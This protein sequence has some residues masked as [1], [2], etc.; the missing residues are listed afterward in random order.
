[1]KSVSAFKMGLVLLGAML[2]FV[3]GS[4]GRADTPYWDANWNYRKQVAITNN[5]QTTLYDYSMNISLNTAELISQGKMQSDC[6]DI[7]II[8]NGQE[9]YYG[10]TNPNSVSTEIYFIANDLVDGNNSD[11]YIYYGSPDA[12]DGF[13]QNWKDAFYIWWDD[14]DT[15]RGWYD[16]WGRGGYYTVSDGYMTVYFSPYTDVAYCPGDGSS[17]PMDKMPGLKAETK[18]M[19][20]NS[21]SCQGQ[22]VLGGWDFGSG[23]FPIP[24]ISAGH[25]RYAIGYSGLISKTINPNQWYTAEFVYNRLTGDWYGTLNGELVSGNRPALGSDDFSTIIVSGCNGNDPRVD[26]IYLRYFIEPEP[27]CSLGPEEYAKPLTHDECANAIAVQANVPYN[28]STQYATGTDTSSCSYKDTNDVWHSFTPKFDY[29]YTISLCGSAFDTTLAI[30]DG[31][32]GTELACNDDSP[33]VVCPSK[34]QSQLTISLLKDV[35]YFIRI[36]GYNSQTGDYT[37]TIIGPRCTEYPVMDFN[38]DC[39]VDF[40]DLAIF[41]RSWLD[42]NLDPPHVCWQ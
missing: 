40:N 11:I 41:C 31:C 6:G 36:A 4:V 17:F 8:E 2:L 38:K 9:I 13:V 29:E 39:K 3:M 21:R 19:V 26:Y 7:R 25:N 27:S 42:C 1:M 22:I 23:G 32:G 10:I 35:T 30:F 14:F 5:V 33:P 28:G 24:D 37:L 20:L 16:A 12:N 18:M 15:D 34:F